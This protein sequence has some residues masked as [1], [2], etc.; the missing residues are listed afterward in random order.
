MTLP[1]YFV[2]IPTL[3]AKKPRFDS[4]RICNVKH[5]KKPIFSD[6][7]YDKLIKCF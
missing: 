6:K 1:T 3:V 2:I 4:T 7:Q 5:V